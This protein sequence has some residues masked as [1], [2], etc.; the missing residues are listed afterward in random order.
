VRR[1]G[2]IDG[3][4]LGR[5]DGRWLDRINWG[6]S[7]GDLILQLADSMALTGK[8]Y[9]A[10]LT[11]VQ[12]LGVVKGAEDGFLLPMVLALAQ[13]S[14]LGVV[15]GVRVSWR[16][17]A[18]LFAEKGS[19]C[20]DFEWIGVVIALVDVLHQGVGLTDIIFLL[21][22]VLSIT[23]DNKTGPLQSVIVAADGRV[24]VAMVYW[25]LLL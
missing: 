9:G 22:S 7:P 6:L 1:L 24:D 4:W 8:R 17:A 21:L 10:F 2:R 23:K 19:G 25:G 18:Q 16:G 5:I 13:G 3:R 15:A 11:K 14:C 12:R 20:S